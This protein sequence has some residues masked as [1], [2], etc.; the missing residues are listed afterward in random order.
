MTPKVNTEIEPQKKLEKKG[1][2]ASADDLRRF[3]K[4][5]WNSGNDIVLTGITTQELCSLD[6]DYWAR[7]RGNQK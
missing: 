4:N 1:L 5:F 2:K 3:N 6:K 7:N